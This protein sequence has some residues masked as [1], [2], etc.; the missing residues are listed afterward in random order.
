LGE[1]RC[2]PIRTLLLLRQLDA[3]ELAAQILQAVPVGECAYQF[4]RHLGAIDRLGVHAQVSLQHGKIE[5]REVENLE[6][7]GIGQERL[8]ARRLVIAVGE[9]NQMAFAEASRKLD[10]AQPVAL[11]LE[12]H[13]LG[14][15]GYGAAERQSG[16]KIAAMQMR[17]HRFRFH[18][19]SRNLGAQEKTRTSKTFRP[20]EPE[21]SASTNS[22]TWAM[23]L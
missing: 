10:Q 20:L 16:G 11:R 3:Q 4:R 7:L 13:R 6:H 21:S 19:R 5:A 14:V 8:Q 1:R 23:A 22:A 15:D 9:L 12:A 17:V 2:A 18:V